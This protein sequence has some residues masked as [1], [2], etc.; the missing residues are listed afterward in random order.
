[1][2][3]HCYSGPLDIVRHRFY[4][5]ATT[6]VFVS[7]HPSIHHNYHHCGDYDDVTLLLVVLGTAGTVGTIP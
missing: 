3:Y 7:I 2:S 4:D 1:M 6:T 5:D